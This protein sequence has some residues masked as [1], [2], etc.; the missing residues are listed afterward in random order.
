MAEQLKGLMATR[1]QMEKKATQG[2]FATG[3]AH[4]IRNPLATIKVC[5]Q[6]LP[7]SSNDAQ[8][9]ELKQLMLE[10]IDRIN[11]L[12]QNLLDYSRPPNPS[13]CLISCNSLLQKVMTLI[14]PMAKDHSINL[15]LS[16]ND[17]IQLKADP[18]QL[19]QVI[20]NL[21]LNSIEAISGNAASDSNG[22]INLGCCL[23][24]SK[25][26]ITITDNGPGI[27]ESD[28]KKVL[29]PFFT[30]KTSGTGL[31][32]AISA[33]LV[34]LNGGQLKLSSQAG[35]GTTVTLTFDL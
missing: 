21:L 22:Q 2:D 20:L 29:D 23:E 25:A 34:E 27:S 14:E 12:I 35:S 19:H 30:T 28:Q 15:T 31:G 17:S 13:S 24:S 6:S 32:L 3:V 5:L 16:A 10:E 8:A 9:T 7:L 4:E 26:I 1:I 18:E 11:H 33:R